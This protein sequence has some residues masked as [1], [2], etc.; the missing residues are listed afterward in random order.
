[1]CLG[2]IRVDSVVGGL[3]ADGFF[4]VVDGGEETYVMDGGCACGGCETEDCGSLADGEGVACV[5]GV[6]VSCGHVPDEG[7]PFG[8]F[9]SFC[10]NY[11]AAVIYSVKSPEIG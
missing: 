4:D 5:V 11:A 10:G 7:C 3:D 1:M 6:E 8:D 2:W 9:L